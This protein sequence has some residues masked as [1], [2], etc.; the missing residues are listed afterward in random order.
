MYEIQLIRHFLRS[1][2]KRIGKTPNFVILMLMW[3]IFVQFFY[4]IHSMKV[5][6]NR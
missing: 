4:E 6:F 1:C 2:K 3:N 5:I